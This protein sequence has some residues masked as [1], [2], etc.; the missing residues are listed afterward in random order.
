MRM[1]PKL[2]RDGEAARPKRILV[3]GS[4]GH[5]RRVESHRWDRLPDAINVCAGNS[6]SRECPRPLR[7]W[8]WQWQWWRGERDW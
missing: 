7:R 2:A 6:L 5:G 3:V 4:D 1:T 8:Q